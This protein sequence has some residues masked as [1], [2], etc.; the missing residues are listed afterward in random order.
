MDFAEKLAKKLKDDYVSVEHLMLGIF[1]N[2][3]PAIKHIFQMHNITKDGFTEE[4]SKV[5]T[6]HGRP[7]TGKLQLR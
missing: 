2:Q 3:T 4:L 6:G 5:K 7:G 1:A